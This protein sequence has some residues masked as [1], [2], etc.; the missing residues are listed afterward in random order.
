MKFFFLYSAAMSPI[1]L[2][3]TP[4]EEKELLAK[5][6]SMGINVTTY[7]RNTIRDSLRRNPETQ[8]AQLNRS[9]RA[10]IS[11]MAEGCGVTQAGDDKMI[12]ELKSHM[13]AIFDKDRK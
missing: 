2:A 12:S 10:L 6:N 11:A 1:E 5:A 3:F 9:V 4:A 13:L 7:V 8:F